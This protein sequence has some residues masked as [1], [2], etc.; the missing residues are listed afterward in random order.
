[1]VPWVGVC[2]TVLKTFG[3]FR[4][5]LPYPISD[6]TLKIHTVISLKH[7][8]RY[9]PPCR[10]GNDKTARISD[11]PM[12]RMRLR[13]QEASSVVL[14]FQEARKKKKDDN[15]AKTFGSNIKFQKREQMYA[16]VLL[17]PPK[18]CKHS[19][20]QTIA[21]AVVTLKGGFCPNTQCSMQLATTYNP[22][23]NPNIQCEHIQCDHSIQN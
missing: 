4:R 8:P 14:Q 5:K 9:A 3:Y 10:G 2:R 19:P 11:A 13:T 21:I 18:T 15:I 6:L 1:M 23:F 12:R 22:T 16:Y 7:R 17:I 20:R